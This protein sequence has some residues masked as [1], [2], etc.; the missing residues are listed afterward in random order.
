MQLEG[1]SS[2]A[3]ITYHRISDAINTVMLA[4]LFL[5]VIRIILY[6]I[7]ADNIGIVALI[8][9]VTDLFSLPLQNS[10]SALS[11]GKYVLDTPAAVSG[12]IILMSGN[13]FVFIIDRYRVYQ[14]NKHHNLEM[15]I[16]F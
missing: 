16:I 4:M 5:I 15:K 11:I 6:L 13:T 7:G 12:A 9:W 10:I 1:E 2:P 3:K 8:Y 14:K